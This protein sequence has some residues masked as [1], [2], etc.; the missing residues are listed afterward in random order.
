MP[1]TET[2]IDGAGD[3]NAG[4]RGN[5]IASVDAMRGL[6]I[7]LMVFVNDLGKAAPSWMLHIQPPGADGMTLA[8]IVFPLFLFIAGVSIPLAVDTARRRGMSPFTVVAHILTRTLGLLLMGLVGVNLSEGTSMD[9]QLW[10][11]LAY[12][13]IILA[14]CIVPNGPAGKRVALASL[15]VIG[16][17]GLGL[18]YRNRR[19]AAS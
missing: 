11:L 7:L 2:D 5:R 9:P 13:A 8:D 19:R 15:K 1:G 4:S 12:V 6:T 3:S 16:A 17:I 14:W 10:G 18:F